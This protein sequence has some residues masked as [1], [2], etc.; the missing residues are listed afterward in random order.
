MFQLFRYNVLQ[1][2]K[3]N[4]DIRTKITSDIIRVIFQ[5]VFDQ[6]VE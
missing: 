3:S 4:L 5:K 1:Q 2:F 6:L